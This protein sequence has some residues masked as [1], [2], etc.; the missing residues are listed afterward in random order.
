[1]PRRGAL[2][3]L[4]ASTS[5]A[6]AR[7]L[8]LRSGASNEEIAAAIP[9][10]DL[11]AAYRELVAANGGGSVDEATLVRGAALA[12]RIRKEFAPHGHE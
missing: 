12:R 2:A 7:A 4:T 9:G 11:R 6:V 5:R 3:D 8:G 10:D 1:M